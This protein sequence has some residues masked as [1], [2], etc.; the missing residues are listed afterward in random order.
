MSQT[1]SVLEVVGAAII[2]RS[3]CLAAQRAADSVREALK[4]EFPGGKVEAGETPQQALRREVREELGLEVEIEAWLGRGKHL[5]G[6]VLIR[7]DI[8]QARIIGGELV[9]NEHHRHGWFA[10]DELYEL[11]WA[12]ADRPVLPAIVDRLSEKANVARKM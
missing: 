8:Y 7:L 10:P 2:E 5:D 11:D 9:R 1:D 4:W 6:E 12:A 3:R